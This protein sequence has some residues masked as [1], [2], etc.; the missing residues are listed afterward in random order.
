M[1]DVAPVSRW[2]GSIDEKKDDFRPG[3]PHDSDESPVRLEEGNKS[4]L[5]MSEDE[6]TA[7]TKAHP[8]ESVPI[9]INFGPG[10]LT[11]PRNW[12]KWKRW[13]IT[14]FAC[15]LNVI[16]YVAANS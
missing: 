12:P 8:K 11:N 14:C 10:D 7:Y 16:T 13:Y 3:S 5:I 1:E 15:F 2:S 4:G 6:A 9:Y